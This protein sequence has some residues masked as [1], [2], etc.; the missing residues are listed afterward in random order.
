MS[1]GLHQQWQ[2][3]SL[4]DGSYSL[5]NSHSSQAL[6]VW[7]MS[8]AAGANIAQWPY[9]G[10]TG[11]KCTLEDAGAGYVRIR[12]VLSGLVLDV[13]GASSANDANVVQWKQT[14]GSNQQ[15]LLERL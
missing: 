15:W 11:Q 14:G 2:L 12:S 13:S 3:I 4:G 8:T 6:D 9:W 10:G 7:E 1:R 5:I